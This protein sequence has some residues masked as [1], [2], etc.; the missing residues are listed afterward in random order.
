[1]RARTSGA[2]YEK[3]ENID[4]RF[5]IENCIGRECP[6]P[7]DRGLDRQRMALLDINPT[8]AHDDDPMVMVQEL[9]DEPKTTSANKSCKSWMS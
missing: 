2:L 8:G 5:K 9:V 7:A 3:D 6:R 4:V 1:M